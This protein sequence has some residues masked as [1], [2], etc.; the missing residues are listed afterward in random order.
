MRFFFFLC[1]GLRFRVSGF[2]SLG[3]RGWGLGFRGWGLGFREVDLGLGFR[4]QFGFGGPRFWD[5]PGTKITK[6]TNGK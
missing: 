4:I 3:L 6:E 5:C 1:W 2:W